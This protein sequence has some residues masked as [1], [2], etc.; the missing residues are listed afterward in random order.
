MAM[1]K[2]TPGPWEVAGKSGNMGEAF[3]IESAT[4][5]VAWTSNSLGLDDEDTSLTEEEVITK[6]DEDNAKVI[7]QAPELLE[8]LDDVTAALETLL[9]HYGPS[10]LPLKGMSVHDYTQRLKVVTRARKLTDAWRQE[11]EDDASGES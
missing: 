1:G 7:A 8:A 10:P 9:M 4:R 2:Y 6:E 5:T 3:V 11:E